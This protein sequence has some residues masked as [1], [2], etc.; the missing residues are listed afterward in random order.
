MV[1][2]TKNHYIRYQYKGDTIR[3]DLPVINGYFIIDKTMFPKDSDCHEFKISVFRSEEGKKED[4][5][6]TE[7]MIVVIIP[8]WIDE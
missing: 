6:Y 8:E 1:N 5:C 7:E 3:K 2:K 4:Y